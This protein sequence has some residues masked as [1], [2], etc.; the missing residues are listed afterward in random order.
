MVEGAGVFQRGGRDVRVLRPRAVVCCFLVPVLLV[1]AAAS[2]LRSFIRGLC[3]LRK[4][5]GLRL[6][7]C[8]AVPRVGIRVALD[9]FALDSS[10]LDSSV[11]DS[12]QCVR[13]RRSC[14]HTAIVL[15]ICGVASNE[16]IHYHLYFLSF[17][18]LFPYS[19]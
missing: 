4:L 6:F 2:G 3:F 5:C 17:D 1:V 18:Y 14:P 12:S 13:I 15:V 19:S 8:L 11:L 10:V 7:F 16:S 9:S